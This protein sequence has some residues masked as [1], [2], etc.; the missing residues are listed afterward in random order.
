MS[1]WVPLR[2]WEPNLFEQRELDW[3]LPLKEQMSHFGTLSDE[4]VTFN[5][6]ADWSLSGT[7]DKISGTKLACHSRRS[8]SRLRRELRE[9][10]KKSH[11]VC[12][13]RSIWIPGTGYVPNVLIRENNF[14]GAWPAIGMLSCEFRLFPVVVTSAFA[15]YR[16]VL[17]KY[18]YKKIFIDYW[19]EIV[20]MCVIDRYPEAKYDFAVLTYRVLKWWRHK[21]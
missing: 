4:P 7:A 19:M 10:W 9:W 14:A 3:C 1:W 16:Y 6:R 20:D 17:Q 5:A 21:N 15:G 18:G 2:V 13:V 12:T 11:L 8:N